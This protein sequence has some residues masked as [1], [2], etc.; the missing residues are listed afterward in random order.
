M[1]VITPLNMF[2]ALFVWDRFSIYNQLIDTVCSHLLNDHCTH[3]Q[4]MYMTFDSYCFIDFFLV[5]KKRR[6]T[7]MKN[8]PEITAVILVLFSF[9]RYERTCRTRVILQ[10]C[11][12]LSAKFCWYC[13][14]GCIWAGSWKHKMSQ[15]HKNSYFQ[16]SFHITSFSVG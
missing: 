16:Q 15:F 6:D 11:A 12:D 14:D 13:T 2:Y 10:K 7:N 8:A 4:I 5:Y 9:L 3:W 1:A